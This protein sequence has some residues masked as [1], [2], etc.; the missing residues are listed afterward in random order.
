MAQLSPT[1]E[2]ADYFLQPNSFPLLPLIGWAATSFALHLAPQHADQQF[3]A[4]VV[5]STSSMYYYI[6]LLDNVMDGH[7]TTEAQILPAMAFFHTE[8]QSPYQRYFP[9][10]HPFWLLFR[11]AWLAGNEAV[12]RELELDSFT[13]A[14]FESI[15][16]AKLSAARIPVA[17]VAFRANAADRL[18][19]WDAFTVA[20][21]RWSQMEDDLF[22]WHHDLRHGKS[23]YFLSEARRS[24]GANT[25]NAPDSA[26]SEDALSAWIVQIGFDQEIETLRREL[27]VLRDLAERLHSTDILDYLDCRRA[28]LD[29]DS[30]RI[31]LAFK[32]LAEIA[33][34]TE[35]RVKV[36]K[37]SCS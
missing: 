33:G 23:S 12:A 10:D 24:C 19:A 28:M 8:F 16:V 20:L 17:A 18:P 21:S 9:P 26:H 32:T 29:S 5:Y 11:S 37:G 4:D 31:A 2:P 27:F 22:D 36:V 15:S 1:A 14:D 25:A 30:R 6:R 3:V 7:A 35:A 34:I 13:R